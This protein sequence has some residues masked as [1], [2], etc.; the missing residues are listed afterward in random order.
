MLDGNIMKTLFLA[1]LTATG[2]LAQQASLSGLVTDPTGA[3]VP[4]ARIALRNVDTGIE[5]TASTNPEGYYNFP[6][7]PPGRYSL[8]AESTGFKSVVSTGIRLD[9]EQK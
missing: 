3:A 7:V 2:L 5:Q 9:V 6:L 8:T 1:L 4:N